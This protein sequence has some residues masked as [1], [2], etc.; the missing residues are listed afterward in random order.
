[1]GL[2]NLVGKPIRP[3]IITA[4]HQITHSYIMYIMY[5]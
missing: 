1:M 5:N 3:A 4:P 2:A